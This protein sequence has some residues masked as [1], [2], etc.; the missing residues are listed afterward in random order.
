MALFPDRLSYALYFFIQRR[1]GPGELGLREAN[2]TNNL[3][4][5]VRIAD[6]IRS[7]GR[8]LNGRTI[9]EPG[10]GRRLT[11]PMASWLCCAER[12]LTTDL[13]RYLRYEFVCGDIEYMRE[14]RKDIQAIF[15]D[16]RGQPIFSRGSS[17]C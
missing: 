17:T 2:P 8:P 7:Q 5:G 10:T 1:F 6:M 16:Y 12:I 14:H 9:L 3:A 11:L 15:K 4:T 13:N